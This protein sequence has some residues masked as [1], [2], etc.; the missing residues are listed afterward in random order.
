MKRLLER[1]GVRT[2]SF[3]KTLAILAGTAAAATVAAVVMKK[4]AEKTT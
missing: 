3:K 1:S 4:K 2:V